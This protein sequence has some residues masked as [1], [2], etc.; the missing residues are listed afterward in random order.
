[1]EFVLIGIVGLLLGG[2][3]NVIADAFL[4]GRVTPPQY[5]EGATRPLLAWLGS[6]AFVFGLRRSRRPESSAAAA[7]SKGACK[8]AP[9][10]RLSWRYPLAEL[11]LALVLVIANLRLGDGPLSQQVIQTTYFALF[12]LIA[13][14]DIE[15]KRIPLT[16]L[17]SLAAM[18][19]V[20]ALLFTDHAPTLISSMVG[21]GIGAALF[22]LAY[23][24]GE[25]FKRLLEGRRN[26]TLSS[27]AMGLGEVYLLAI[28]GL[29]VGFPNVL[30]VAL[31]AILAGGAGSLAWLAQ[32]RLRGQRYEPLTALP[33][34]HNILAA[35][36]AVLL[37][38]ADISRIFW[39]IAV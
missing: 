29:I 4:T 3:V 36:A 26:V 5:P 1:M 22:Y 30:A 24:G 19:L 2:A 9:G 39:G 21:G 10:S 32:L 6:A 35:I 16:L 11:A 12:L 23:L 37:F 15:R 18:A 20:A 17:V 14:I 8:T 31:L 38:P 28:G 34:S 7:S 27:S 33:Y 25:Q 13:V